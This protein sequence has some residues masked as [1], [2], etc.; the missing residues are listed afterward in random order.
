[1]GRGMTIIESIF[2]GYQFTDDD[3]TAHVHKEVSREQERRERVAR[4]LDRQVPPKYRSASISML[5]PDRRRLAERVLAGA[6]GIVIGGN[7]TGKTTFLFTVMRELVERD[8]PVRYA[9]AKTISDL[10]NLAVLDG[11]QTLEDVIRTEWGRR[12]EVL[13]VD[14]LDKM[15]DSQA[16]RIN[17]YELVDWRYSHMLQTVAV[18]NA[19]PDTI[20]ARIP[21]DVYSRLTGTAEGNFRAIFGGRDMRRNWNESPRC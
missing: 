12:T 15:T 2:P 6:S 21:Q 5:A 13:L 7:G 16:S 10:I 1:M 8:V 14:E 17:L 20:L 19:A 11:R 9:H 3:S 18:A 4:I